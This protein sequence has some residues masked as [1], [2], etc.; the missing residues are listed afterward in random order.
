MTKIIYMAPT[1][2]LINQINP[3]YV[4]ELIKTGVTKKIGDDIIYLVIEITEENI[5]LNN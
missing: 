3:T 5:L 2:E 4:A 1:I